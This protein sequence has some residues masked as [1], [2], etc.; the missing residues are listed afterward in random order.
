VAN[1]DIVAEFDRSIES[2]TQKCVPNGARISQIILQIATFLAEF[3]RA[4]EHSPP[5]FLRIGMD[6]K[7][8]AAFHIRLESGVAENKPIKQKGPP[9]DSG[10]SIKPP[11][12]ILPFYSLLTLSLHLFPQAGVMKLLTPWSLQQ[13]PLL[14]K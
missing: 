10:T 9:L 4:Y 13:T 5:P 12:P 2:W 14:P 3:C 11:P 6:K 8:F 1:F 7:C